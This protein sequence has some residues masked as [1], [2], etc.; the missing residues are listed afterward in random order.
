[1]LRWSR[2]LPLFLI[3]LVIAV[4]AVQAQDAE[5]IPLLTD[6]GMDLAPG[7]RY[8]V[9]MEAHRA[10]WEG[11][12]AEFIAGPLH[13]TLQNTGS[14]KVRLTIKVNDE[15]R[16]NEEIQ[17]TE[18]VTITL[19]IDHDGS[20][21][22]EVSGVGRVGT[23]YIER[24]YRIFVHEEDIS[25]LGHEAH[26]NVEVS[27]QA[28]PGSSSGGGDYTQPIGETN[29]GSGSS[30]MS[31]ILDALGASAV[32]AIVIILVLLG[33]V[34]FLIA[35]TQSAARGWITNPFRKEG[36]RGS[37]GGSSSKGSSGSGGSSSGGGGK[38]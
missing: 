33:F 38:S 1:M 2:V 6:Y 27:R 28:L 17:G 14:M 8:T 24:A 19:Y 31:R 15:E 16:Y 7:Y 4:P 26:S 32:V 23:F 11:T 37:G 3:F 22:I 10:L 12:R 25:H 35:L 21:T 29:T 36:S 5:E 30:L 9:A 34:V 18:S 20:G 13:I